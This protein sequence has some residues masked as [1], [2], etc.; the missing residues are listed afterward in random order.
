[1]RPARANAV[2]LAR[3]YAPGRRGRGLAPWGASAARIYR[4]ISE[5]KGTAL[6][7]RGERQARRRTPT[8]CWPRR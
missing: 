3:D 8:G 1:M 6:A 5:R 7:E 2:E 4:G